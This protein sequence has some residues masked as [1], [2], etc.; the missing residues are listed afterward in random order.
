MYR[1][2]M[3]KLAILA[4]VLAL[5]AGGLLLFVNEKD[6]AAALR[7]SAG[8]I[9][10]GSKFDVQMGAHMSTVDQAFER[11]HFSVYR[12]DDRD[13][14]C[15]SHEYPVSHGVAVYTDDSWR[16]GTVCVAFERKSRK[17][18]SIEWTYGPFRIDL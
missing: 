2:P 14:T 15:L 4:V 18:S 12:S 8:F 9:D 17:V 5:A 11:H 7:S 1:A 10:R 16:K 6:N 3:L 13:Q